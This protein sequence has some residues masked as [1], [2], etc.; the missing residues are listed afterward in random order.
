MSIKVCHF[1][2]VHPRFD[3]RIIKMC[4]SLVTAGFEVYFVVA[5][6]KPNEIID[7][8]RIIS[9]NVKS[10]NRISRMTSVASKVYKTALALNCDIYHFHDPELLFYGLKLRKR[11]YQVI[12]DSHE[13]VPRDILSKYYIWKPSRMFLSFFVEQIENYIASRLNMIITATPFIK[14]RFLKINCNTEVI[15]NFPVLSELYS[16]ISWNDKKNYVCFIGGINVERG[17]Y[18]IVNAMINTTATLQLAGE[19]ET[20]RIFAKAKISKGWN[21][22]KFHGYVNR[23]QARSILSESKAG[24]V[25]YHPHPNHINAQPNKIFEY[26]SASIP[27]IASNFPLWKSMIDL[28]QFGLYVNPMDTNEIAGAINYLIDNPDIASKM[29]ENGRKAVEEKFNWEVEAKKLVGI[30]INLSK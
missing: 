13:D 17:I 28:D 10:T 14:E 7:N 23:Q 3:T 11:N 22:V 20:S 29:G 30:Y 15:N 27:V 8:V 16:K 6:D 18:E 26:M 19:F 24:L 1:S 9:V 5:D 4:R 2:S 25:T 21:K 12:Y